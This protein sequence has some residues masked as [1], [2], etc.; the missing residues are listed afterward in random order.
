MSKIPHSE[1]SIY[2]V[3]KYSKSVHV[4]TSVNQLPV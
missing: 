1:E 2:L 3:L 4:I